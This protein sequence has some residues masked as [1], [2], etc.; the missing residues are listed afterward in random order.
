MANS[1]SFLI[2]GQ[3]FFFF[4]AADD[5]SIFNWSL[6]TSKTHWRLVVL[7]VASVVD[8]LIGWLIDCFAWF[9]WTNAGLAWLRV[10][11]I[12]ILTLALLGYIC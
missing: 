5:F 11:E 8:W 6:F 9:A 12:V 10:W 4:A 1:G 7:R 2:A 3:S